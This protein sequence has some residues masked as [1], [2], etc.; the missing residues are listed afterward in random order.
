MIILL[1]ILS[2]KTVFKLGIVL[3]VWPG[4][5]R[6]G[7]GRRRRIIGRNGGVRLRVRSPSTTPHSL[8]ATDSVAGQSLVFSLGP[9]QWT[10]Q[11]LRI[12]WPEYGHHRRSVISSFSLFIIVL[13]TIFCY[14]KYYNVDLVLNFLMK[15][16]LD[17]NILSFFSHNWKSFAWKTKK[18]WQILT[19]KP[20]NCLF[21]LFFYL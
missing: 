4:S 15:S 9:C 16:D 10:V 17:A 21:W 7:Q 6:W 3:G 1:E 12:R 19:Y 2:T 13:M 14:L 8:S 18:K 20:K 11:W 5:E